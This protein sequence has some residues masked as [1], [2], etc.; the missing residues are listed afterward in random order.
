[1]FP[2]RL[3]IRTVPLSCIAASRKLPVVEIATLFANLSITALF[4][5]K[6]CEVVRD[7][8]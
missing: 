1:M 5:S 8:R 3:R 6:A 2:E 7:R 4:S